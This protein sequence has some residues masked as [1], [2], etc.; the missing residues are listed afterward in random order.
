MCLGARVIKELRNAPCWDYYPF[1]PQVPSHICKKP[2]GLPTSNLWL[3]PDQI[4]SGSSSITGLC[5][6][7]SDRPGS[8]TESSLDQKVFRQ[9]E[10]RNP[11]QFLKRETIF[12]MLSSRSSP[13]STTHIL[14][15]PNTDCY[16][17]F[18]LSWN[19]RTDPTPAASSSNS[20][21]KWFA[22][23]TGG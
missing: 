16:T 7:M 22:S 10:G 20:C 12:E 9:Q 23:Q 2:S 19:S 15:S 5:G 1:Q 13:H 8:P 21:V 18:S 11:F 14:S 4:S 3:I 17:L 6:E